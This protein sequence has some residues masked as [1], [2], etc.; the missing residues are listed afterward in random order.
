PT[1]HIDASSHRF[2]KRLV[3]SRVV[4]LARSTEGERSGASLWHERPELAAMDQG[5]QRFG[6]LT[7]VLV[8]SVEHFAQLVAPA[9]DLEAEARAQAGECGPRQDLL[10]LF[11][12]GDL[13]LA[14]GPSVTP[15]AA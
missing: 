14:F 8:E 4:G 15:A 5:L 10:H 6:D 2:S 3:Q 13:L 7:L 1:L 12:H 11:V 9:V